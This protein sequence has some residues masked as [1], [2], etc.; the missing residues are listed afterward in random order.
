M[1]TV[2]TSI[3]LSF[4]LFSVSVN[5][6]QQM[7]SFGAPMPQNVEA[8]PL[9][10]ALAQLDE[11]QAKQ[12]KVSG[13]VTEVCQA[14]GCWMILVDGEQFA[15]IT[16][17]DYSF[18]VPTETSMQ[19]AVIYGTL[20]ASTLNAETAAHY[21]QDAGDQEAHDRLLASE[22][23]VKEYSLVASAVLIEQRI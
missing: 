12:V 23:A 8:V 21:A 15:R 1:K 7:Q 9:S 14:K 18:F 17:K 13:Q 20:E 19:N 2:L 6:D 11:G 22:L 16:F 3:L 4:A 10:A 5:A